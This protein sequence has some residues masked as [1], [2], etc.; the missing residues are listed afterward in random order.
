MRFPLMLNL[1]SFLPIILST[2]ALDSTWS[3][4]DDLFQNS[5][6]P[7]PLD[8][9]GPPLALTTLPENTYFPDPLEDLFQDTNSNNIPLFDDASFDNFELAGCSASEYL[10]AIGKSRFRRRDDPKS[11]ANT[12]TP[13]AAADTL[14]GG[15]SDTIPGSTS[16]RNSPPRSGALA[17]ALTVE[18]KNSFCAT[19]TQG[20]LPWGLCSSGIVTDVLYIN[21]MIFGGESFPVCWV[22]H[23]TLGMLLVTEP[24]SMNFD[25]MSA[26]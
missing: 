17:R 11:C 21:S 6:T 19:Y 16:D 5:G 13:P 14:P 7:L 10:P 8:Q 18:D 1:I 26:D 2:I 24:S 15:A 23:C 25:F 9:T 22:N 3:S 12:M 4:D 20:E